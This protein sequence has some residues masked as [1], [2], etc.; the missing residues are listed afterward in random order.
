MTRAWTVREQPDRVG[1]LHKVKGLYRIRES[2][3]RR[4]TCALGSSRVR[5]PARRWH[6]GPDEENDSVLDQDS[7]SGV[8]DEGKQRDS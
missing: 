6:V 3:E 1:L 7:A 5:D 2:G 8:E 4:W